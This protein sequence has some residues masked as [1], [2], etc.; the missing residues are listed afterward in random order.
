[1]PFVSFKVK[2][3][4]RGWRGPF[5]FVSRSSAQAAVPPGKGKGEGEGEGQS[6]ASQ[7]TERA[8]W[9]CSVILA[10]PTAEPMFPA[11][12]H[13]DL[14]CTELVGGWPPQLPGGG[15]VGFFSFHRGLFEKGHEVPSKLLLLSLV[16][17]VSLTL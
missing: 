11:G 8:R 7:G 13:I 12:T 5:P 15:L 1:M 17:G 3:P 4:P 2:G 10:R 16:F 14:E 9:L 6:Q